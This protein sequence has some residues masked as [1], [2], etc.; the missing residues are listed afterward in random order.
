MHATVVINQGSQKF[1]LRWI[2]DASGLDFGV[3][4]EAG[5]IILVPWGSLF[6]ILEGPRDR[7][8]GLGAA[9]WLACRPRAPH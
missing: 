5:G 1:G 3:I 4:L 8:G 7:A 2:R 6:L 9:S